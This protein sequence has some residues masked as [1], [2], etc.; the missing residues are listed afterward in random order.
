MRRRQRFWQSQ[1][2]LYLFTLDTY[3]DEGCLVNRA[4]GINGGTNKSN[5]VRQ[6]DCHPQR[7][8]RTDTSARMVQ[9]LILSLAL[10]PVKIVDRGNEEAGRSR[11]GLE[12][13][14]N[15]S[16]HQGSTQIWP[17]WVDTKGEGLGRGQEISDAMGQVSSYVPAYRDRAVPVSGREHW[18]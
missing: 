10:P 17:I 7:N 13:F 18:D 5:N 2:L 3:W 11:D 12:V 15:S 4:E 6:R 16:K 9:I 1:T 14:C 8:S